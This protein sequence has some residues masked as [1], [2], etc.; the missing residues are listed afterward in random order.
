MVIGQTLL[1][2]RRTGRA[3]RSYQARA[4]AL[5]RHFAMTY[6]RGSPKLLASVPGCQPG[7]LI[8]VKVVISWPFMRLPNWK[9]PAPSTF[10]QSRKGLRRPL[11]PDKTGIGRD[12]TLETP[13]DFFW[14]ATT[15]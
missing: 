4:A 3:I 9:T 7:K 1:R 10:V 14:Q 12:F 13:E 8:L 2:R 15:R 5:T 11:S 6:G